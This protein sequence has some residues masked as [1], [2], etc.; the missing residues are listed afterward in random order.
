[1]K[2]VDPRLLR[3]ARAT[4]IFLLAA[5]A[6]GLAGAGLVVAQAVLLAEVIVGAFQQGAG[7]RRADH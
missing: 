6:L 4:R 7:R 2:P 1:M 5:V 3:Y